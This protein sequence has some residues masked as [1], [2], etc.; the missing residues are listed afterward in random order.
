MRDFY[1]AAKFIIVEMFV[2]A[3]PVMIADIYFVH[4]NYKKVKM[5]GL[6]NF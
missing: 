5:A 2:A 3:A 1:E 6:K 4:L